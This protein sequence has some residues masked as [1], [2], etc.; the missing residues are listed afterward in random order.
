SRDEVIERMVE[1]WAADV[2]EHDSV[3]M[4]A[5]LRADVAELNRRGREVWRAMGRLGQHEVV[6]PG[7]TGYA[8]GDRVVTLAPAA[9]G[10]VV[11]SECGTV[12]G[13]GRGAL[14]IRMDDDH[15]IRRLEGP[16]IGANRLAHAYAVTVHR[17][18][19]ATVE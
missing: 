11:T 10:A 18:Q 17:S 14:L 5:Y 15:Q 3:A 8:T 7:G 2:A 1:A 6:A 9:G 13:L 12:V 19:G 4:Y 16:E